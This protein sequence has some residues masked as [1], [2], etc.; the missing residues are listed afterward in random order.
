MRGDVANES[1]QFADFASAVQRDV[2]EPLVRLREGG[3]TVAKAAL[4]ARVG[5]KEV[6]VALDRAARAA[7]RYAAAHAKAAATCTAAGIPPQP[8]WSP[9]PPPS[10]LL[11]T[12]AEQKAK[13]PRPAFDS[14]R[15]PVGNT[16]EEEEENEDEDAVKSDNGVTS[17][18]GGDVGDG[19]IS[20]SSHFLFSTAA[21]AANSDKN[22][23]SYFD[24][25]D[26]LNE[27][28]G[29][30]EPKTAPQMSPS[31]ASTPTPPA[32][33]TVTPK[34]GGLPPHLPVRRFSGQVG[35]G[36]G[37]GG[38]PGSV[39]VSVFGPGSGPVPSP[40]PDTRDAGLALAVTLA[41]ARARSRAGSRAASVG[42]ASDGG[43][44]GGGGGSFASVGEA[45]TAGATAV[46]STLKRMFFRG[47]NGLAVPPG[48]ASQTTAE[49]IDV[50]RAAAAATWVACDDALAEAQD[51]WAAF[52]R[53]RDR[54]SS[55][56]AAT[57]VIAAD[58]E[59]KRVAELSDCLRRYTVFAASRAANIQYDVQRLSA[60]AEAVAGAPALT[61]AAVVALRV[62]EAAV[63]ARAT[64]ENNGT[65]G[66]QLEHLFVAAGVGVGVGGDR[67]LSAADGGWNNH[68]ARS[69]HSSITGA[70][71]DHGR[72]NEPQ[73]PLIA[74]L[75]GTIATGM[76][77]TPTH[78]AIPIPIPIQDAVAAT[79]AV[80]APVV[81]SP[82]GGSGGGSVAGGSFSS[83]T[84]KERGS[85]RKI[86]SMFS[87]AFSSKRTTPPSPSLAMPTFDGAKDGPPSM[88][89]SP[90]GKVSGG[91]GSGSADRAR[92][93]SFSV[94]G[95][96]ASSLALSPKAVAAGASLRELLGRP[97][98]GTSKSAEVGDRD[99]SAVARGPSPSFPMTP[100]SSSGCVSVSA[101]ASVGVVG[102]AHTMGVKETSAML[103]H[104]HI[105]EGPL[106]LLGAALF[107]PLAVSVYVNAE[108]VVEHVPPAAMIVP[109]ITTTSNRALLA[110][111]LAAFTGTGTGAEGGETPLAVETP[112]E[113]PVSPD[114]AFALATTDVI[115]VATPTPVP[116]ARRTSYTS[117]PS[118][119]VN[120]A[121]PALLPAALRAIKESPDGVSRLVMALDARRAEGCTR[122][123]TPSFDAVTQLLLSALDVIQARD[124]FARAAALMAISQDFFCIAPP[125]PGAGA[126]PHRSYLQTKVRSHALWQNP[127]YWEAAVYDAI[128]AEVSKFSAGVASEGGKGG[129]WST[130]AK[131]QADS[132]RAMDAEM[133]YVQL[134]IFAFTMVSF[135]HPED[136]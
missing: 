131:T 134:G 7:A 79:V 133:V 63:E 35:V 127:G 29:E 78:A 122:L 39:S 40:L 8:I 55:A 124:D 14:P 75:S 27:T 21:A 38:V 23:K 51:A 66:P 76:H 85:S 60:K 128:G 43:G 135:R 53:A 68:H 33:A 58:L 61:R 77:T 89:A 20:S 28:A 136:R 59:R 97:R 108:G 22:M 82:G 45:A 50:L 129:G 102:T 80:T 83:P 2:L 126:R 116:A 15:A 106:E 44:G 67:S 132:G 12:R 30:T 96:L 101:S 118:F 130:K 26:I 81:T 57:V 65:S 86:F 109:I 10:P 114:F 100:S 19:D 13:N 4:N 1:V 91:G 112:T 73:I 70:S 123:T 90:P 16:Q 125:A 52:L 110:T 37:G 62:A 120:P 25:D 103:Q 104:L 117:A 9:P 36:G 115:G 32:T 92:V 98:S 88:P 17:E 113:A 5:E 94:G 54:L 31:V 105:S 56:F 42:S 34:P 18:A 11:P 69:R 47:A 46:S 49:R 107:D 84:G 74:L 24:V 99:N 87:G 41:G 93:G 95:A 6:K 121:V 71:G 111:T 119:D 3:E 64:V 72:T 48:S